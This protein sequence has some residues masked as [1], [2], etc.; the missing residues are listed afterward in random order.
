VSIEEDY[1]YERERRIKAEDRVQQLR[2]ETQLQGVMGA[3]HAEVER[4]LSE[5]EALRRENQAL[6]LAQLR[7]EDRI[8]QIAREEALKVILEYDAQFAPEVVEVDRS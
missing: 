8:R 7:D 3:V 5:V 4:L 2:R 1:A 6:H